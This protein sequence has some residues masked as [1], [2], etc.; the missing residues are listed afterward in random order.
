MNSMLGTC[1]SSKQTKQRALSLG[2][3]TAGHSGRSFW[4]VTLAGRYL[5]LLLKVVE[6]VA[7]FIFLV[8]SPNV[9]NRI[10]IEVCSGHGF[11]A[12][13]CGGAIWAV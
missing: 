1:G 7:D 13:F 10:I 2:L 3:L 8:H 6:H 5:R 9:E 4:Q 11:E 12:C